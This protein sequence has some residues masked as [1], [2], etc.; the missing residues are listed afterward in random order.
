MTMACQRQRRSPI[1]GWRVMTVD[2][3]GTG[4]TYTVRLADAGKV[5]TVKVTFTDDD[6]YEE[7]RTSEPTNRR[8]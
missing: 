6:G 1:S 4:T 8:G 7:E 2:T 3:R 5:I